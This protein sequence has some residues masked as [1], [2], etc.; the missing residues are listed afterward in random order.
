MNLQDIEA[1]N[2]IY[3]KLNS[4]ITKQMVKYLQDQV[5]INNDTRNIFDILMDAPEATVN[6][7]RRF[8]EL[9]KYLLAYKTKM[10]S[11]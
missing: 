4:Y 2:E 10:L 11:L 9:K 7:I 5:N 8:Q 6:H 1:F 3:Y